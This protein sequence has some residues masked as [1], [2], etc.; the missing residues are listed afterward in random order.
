MNRVLP[1]IV[2]FGLV[3]HGFAVI[4][5]EKQDATRTAVPEMSG[6]LFAET[7]LGLLLV[8]GLIF[9]LGWLMKRFG[10]LPTTGKG[11]INILGGVSLGP[12]ERAVLIQ[13]EGVKL[14]VGVAPG[15]VSML[16]VVEDSGDKGITPDDAF[17]QTLDSELDGEAR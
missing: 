17:A 11:L 5:Q 15:R 16:H 6:G 10:R 4:A 1:S 7:F 14:L 2:G 13:V 12:R 9:A 8:L 3:L